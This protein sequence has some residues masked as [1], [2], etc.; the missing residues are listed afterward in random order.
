[1]SGGRCR[2]RA[3]LRDVMSSEVKKL[4]QLVKRVSI[5]CVLCI[6]GAAVWHVRVY[7][8]LPHHVGGTAFC[9]GTFFLLG[10]WRELCGVCRTPHS[11][12]HGGL[13]H[14]VFL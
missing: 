5:T 4:L 7:V 10:P 9:L 8:Q 1:L 13:C 14:H 11:S 3:C 6:P 12:H 2:L